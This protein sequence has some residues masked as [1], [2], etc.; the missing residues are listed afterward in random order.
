MGKI[1]DMI[2]RWLDIM[3]AQDTGIVIQEPISYETNVQKNRIWYR[4]DPSELDQ[5]F[6]A[7]AVDEVSRARFWASSPSKSARIRK[8]HSG[9]PGMTVN[10]LSSIV[11]GDMGEIEFDKEQTPPGYAEIWSEIAKENKF[12]ALVAEAV[13]EVLVTGDGA[14]KISIDTDLSDYPIIEFY[15]GEHVVYTHNRGR[16]EEIGFLSRHSVGGDDDSMFAKKVKEYTL[17]DRYGKGYIRYELLDSGGEPVDDISIIPELAGLEDATYDANINLAVPMQF[18]ASPKWPGRGRSIYD[19]KTDAYDALDETIS[20]WQDAI[21][22]GRVKRYIPE[23][24]IPRD[25]STGAALPVNV[26]DNQYSMIS[27]PLAEDGQYKIITEQP[28]I[29]TDG[30]LETYIN[31]LDLCLQGVVSPST[32]G[33]DVKKLDNAEAQREKEKTTLYTRQQIVTVL[34][35][36]IPEVVAVALSAYD[37]MHGKQAPEIVCTVDYGEYANPSFEAQ[38]E[39]VGKAA[40]SRIM[41]I[42]AQVRTLWGDT[43]EE[44][45]ILEEVARI[46]QEQGIAE[47]EEPS[48]VPHGFLDGIEP[49]PVPR[50]GVSGAPTSEMMRTAKQPHPEA[51]P[52][53]RMPE[54]MTKTA[55]RSPRR[56]SRASRT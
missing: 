40:A 21:R 2:R 44:D 45:W 18:Y 25:P 30:Y 54:A 4:G 50:G 51:M 34:Q 46:K 36:V 35:D 7:I 6:H 23:T 43:R 55:R 13:R 9:L 29:K 11:V 20:Q 5:M 31:N 49:V 41:S 16:V 32:L 38:V 12:K 19:L 26:L 14:F 47:M 33:I 10:I 8:M 52:M 37:M 1:K 39:T 27:Q 3:P 15:S 48:V 42:E 22:S 56:G 24:M 28:D 53:R 17:I